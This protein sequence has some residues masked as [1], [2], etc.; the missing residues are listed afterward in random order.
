MKNTMLIVIDM[1]NDFVDGALGSK[2]ALAMAPELI[3][4]VT[5]FQGDIIFTRDTHGDDYLNTQEGKNLPV[6]HCIRDTEGWQLFGRLR[7]LA[8]NHTVI[9]KQ[10]FGSMTLPQFIKGKG[11]PDT[12]VLCGVCTDICVISNAMILKA[13]FPETE[14]M[15]D[16]RCCA[17][18]TPENHE[19]ALKAMKQCQIYIL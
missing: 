12:I 5:S 10:T 6:K 9:D 7:E 18:T 1:Q 16:S 2:E 4:E 8:K 17:G 15:V 13:A 11:V 3:E 19:N 14:I